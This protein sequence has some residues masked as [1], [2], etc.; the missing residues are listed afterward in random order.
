VPQLVAVPLQEISSPTSYCR[1][2]G[3][4]DGLEEDSGEGSAPN[5]SGSLRNGSND[6]GSKERGSKN[7]SKGAVGWSGYPPPPS[8]NSRV[9]PVTALRALPG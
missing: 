6:N 8:Q 4:Q 7:N 3:E 1:E 5:G 2:D 9:L